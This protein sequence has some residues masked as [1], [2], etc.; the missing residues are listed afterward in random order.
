MYYVFVFIGAAFLIAN[1]LFFVFFFSFKC[2]LEY[3]DKL[4]DSEAEKKC[5]KFLNKV[6]SIY[7][8]VAP[9]PK[10]KEPV[11]KQEP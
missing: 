9:L 4:E 2:T 7:D 10:S 8:F 11:Q 6:V 1:F 5:Q 3:I